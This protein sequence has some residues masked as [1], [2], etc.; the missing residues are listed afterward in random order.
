MYCMLLTP[1]FSLDLSPPLCALFNA[2]VQSDAM[3]LP[4]RH[5]P[6]N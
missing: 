2:H 3:H 4:G 5:V 6:I 1:W